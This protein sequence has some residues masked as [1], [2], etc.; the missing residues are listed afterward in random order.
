MGECFRDGPLSPKSP[1]DQKKEERRRKK[2]I[3]FCYV[4]F[5]KDLKRKSK[6]WFLEG[7]R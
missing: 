6:S 2:Y 1:E 5:N 3:G 4:A 7:E